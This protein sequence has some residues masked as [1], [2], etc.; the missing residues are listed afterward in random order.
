MNADSLRETANKGFDNRDGSL[1]FLESSL[2]LDD[3]GLMGAA[4]LNPRHHVYLNVIRSG[5]VT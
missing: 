3:A 4:I 5:E 2:V 1:K